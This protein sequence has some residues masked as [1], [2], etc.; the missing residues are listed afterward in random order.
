M[1]VIIQG[2]SLSLREISLMSKVQSLNFSPKSNH[3]HGLKNI[4]AKRV[5][6][7]NKLSIRALYKY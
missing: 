7:Y 2:P 3:T 1:H 6:P 5:A 4:K